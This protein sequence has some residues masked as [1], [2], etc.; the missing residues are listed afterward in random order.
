[1]DN[2]KKTKEVLN[3][4]GNEIFRKNMRVIRVPD[5]HSSYDTLYRA[6]EY[7][8]RNAD[9]KD[10]NLAIAFQSNNSKC[11]HSPELQALY[12][13]EVY[14]LH[15]VTNYINLNKQQKVKFLTAP[16]YEDR[17]KDDEEKTLSYSD[18]FIKWLN[19][20]EE[21]R[22]PIPVSATLVMEDRISRI[23]SERYRDR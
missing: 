16:R 8:Y 23:I 22:S 7:A 11:A 9:R 5:D 17:E 13:Y 14:L 1:M 4:Q 12:D 10:D 2:E 20:I 21:E 15:E 18:F 3:E 19:S 6:L